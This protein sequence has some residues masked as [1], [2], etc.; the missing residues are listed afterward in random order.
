MTELEDFKKETITLDGVDIDVYYIESY[1]GIRL[2]HTFKAGTKEP[3][4]VDLNDKQRVINKL[5]DRF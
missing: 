3:V 1:D 4:D 5:P 2:R